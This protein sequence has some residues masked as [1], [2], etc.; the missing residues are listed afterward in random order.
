MAPNMNTF[1]EGEELIV[2]GTYYADNVSNVLQFPSTGPL[3]LIYIGFGN[4]PAPKVP[5]QFNS[6]LQAQASLR[7]GQS[8][9]YLTPMFLP[10]PDPTLNGVNTII[11]IEAG[12]NTQSTMSL[13]DTAGTVVINASSAMYGVS[14]NLLQY[15]VNTSPSSNPVGGCQVSITDGYTNQTISKNNLGIPMQVAYLGSQTGV[16]FSVVAS[17]GVVTEFEVS[18]PL[19]SESYTIPINSSTTVAYL[20]AYLNGTGNY[21]A[22]VISDGNLPAQD[23]D[24]VAS[25]SLPSGVAGTYVYTNVTSYLPDVVY[26]LNNYA[27]NFIFTNSASIV[28]GTVSSSTTQVASAP[29]TNFTGGQSIPPTTADYTNA[30][31]AAE[32]VTGWTV[33]MDSNVPANI[34]MG[35]QHAELMSS[36]TEKNPRRFFSGSTVGDTATYTEG[37]C[38][39]L[40]SITTSYVYPGLQII[41]QTTGLPTTKGGLY[42]AAAC[43][44]LSCGNRVAEP[45]TN[46][47]INGIGVEVALNTSTINGLQKSGCII[48]QQ[49]NSTG[50]PTLINDFTTWQGDNNVENVLNQQVACRFATNYYI[51]N[52]L[53]PYVGQIA[54]GVISLGKVKTQVIAGLNNIMYTGPGS[55][56]WV[57]AWNPA[58]LNLNFNGANMTLAFSAS[59][60]FVGQ[61]RFITSYITVEPLLANL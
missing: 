49:S 5:V 8:A 9:S 46:K 33:F 12:E 17:G 10:S 44:G 13:K 58:S 38:K 43:A 41:S 47:Q 28:S 24:V 21:S 51:N 19:A 2:A 3:P 30:L 15:N 34:M 1:F 37:I 7:G 52:L 59:L 35:A 50:I 54:A 16:T 27:G 14:A 36:I 40:N 22:S 26:W 11:Y 55:S 32:T 6:L 56:G 39:N 25:V 29:N 60:V 31:I 48:I 23:L 53:Q 20:V 18:S 45:L 61:N 4:G 57:A 42:V